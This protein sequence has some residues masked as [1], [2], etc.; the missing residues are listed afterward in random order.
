MTSKKKQPNTPVALITGGAKRVGKIIAETLAEAGYSLVVH[1]HRSLEQAEETATELRDQGTETLVVQADVTKETEVKRMFAE[2]SDRFGRLDALV[3]T[4]SIWRSIPLHEVT[5]KQVRESFEVNTLGTFLCVQHGGLMMAKQETGGGIVTIGDWA[6]ERPYVDHAAYFIAKG[7]ISTL[8]KAMAVELATRNP[9]VRVNC[10]HP[11]P[12]ML[13]PDLSE[14]D[15]AERKEATLLK[16]ADEPRWLAEAALAL[17]KNEFIT[18]AC[19]PVDA[20]KTIHS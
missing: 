15:A 20:G 1:T 3:T 10:L 17:L 13:P 14:E 16:K 4:A 5:A 6:I 18:G 9:K 8:T 19:L 11:G 7:A 12:V 2:C